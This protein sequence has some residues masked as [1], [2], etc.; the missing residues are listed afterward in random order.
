[1]GDAIRTQGLTKYYGRNRGV[2]ELDL[3]VPPGAVFGFLGPNGAGK[4]TTIRL[5]LDLI[6][7]TGGRAEVLGMDTRSHSVEIRR[8]VGYLSGELA[9][10]E[11][12][13]GRELLDYIA[14]LRG[15]RDRRLVGQLCQR[16]DLD[17]AH[18]VHDLSRGNKQKLGLVLALM[19]R[20]EVLILDEP[21]SGLDPLAQQ[22]F[23][24]L[25]REATA[26]GRTVFLSSHVLSEVERIADR[27]GIIRE[28]RLVD[29]LEVSTLKTRALRRF[30]LHFARPV[31]AAAFERLPGVV[32][33]AVSG[34]VVR[35]AVEGPVDALIKA[36]AGHELVNLVSHE[37]DL[38]EIFLA[39]YRRGAPH[40]AA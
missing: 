35:C 36:A 30:E 14:N 9:L 25:L 39:Y 23:H 22:E 18:H 27:V 28:G 13:T 1:M 12:L 11:N 5:L 34:E 32:E 17:P 31:P 2:A 15:L 3:A 19:H 38:E 8:R 16:L 26:E 24:Q 7:P 10:Y 4:T 29:L 6:R 40:A 21:T 20:P 33:V 37:P